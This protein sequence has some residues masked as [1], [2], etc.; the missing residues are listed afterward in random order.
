MVEVHYLNDPENVP[1][2]VAQYCILNWFLLFLSVCTLLS[3]VYKWAQ[4]SC[5]PHK[6]SIRTVQTHTRKYKN[7]LD[8]STLRVT[9]HLQETWATEKV[10]HY[11]LAL[12]WGTS[13]KWLFI[14]HETWY[15][16]P[17]TPTH[18]CTADIYQQLSCLENTNS[19]FIT[20]QK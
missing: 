8:L 3:T 5:C 20:V 15:Q 17:Q 14:I 7:T 13:T 6:N 16:F 10:S 19:F 4:W 12:Q 1:W 18:D 2:V 11:E 9:I